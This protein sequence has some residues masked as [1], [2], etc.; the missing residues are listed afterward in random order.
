MAE[1]VYHYANFTQEQLAPIHAEINE[2]HNDFSS[3]NNYNG[4]LAGH[5]SHQYE[6]IKCKNHV[7]NVL[8]QHIYDFENKT[9][10]SKKLQ[11]WRGE[12]KFYLDNLWVNFQSKTEFNPPHTHSGIFSFVSWLKVPFNIEDEIALY[13]KPDTNNIQQTAHFNFHVLDPYGEMV[14]ERLPVD[15]KWENRIM[16]FPAKAVHSVNPFYTSDEYRISISG[17]F[18]PL[19]RV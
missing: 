13:P 5:L 15:R 16:I 11:L 2:I 14:Y 6:L 18:F 17:N 10:Y 7:E 4:K 8:L 19:L 1:F 9:G 3:A 12:A